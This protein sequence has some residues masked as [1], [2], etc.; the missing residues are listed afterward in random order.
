VAA[1][2]RRL[3]SRLG[4]GEYAELVAYELIRVAARERDFDRGRPGW[5][6]YMERIEREAETGRELALA[7]L[8]YTRQEMARYGRPIPRLY[9]VGADPDDPGDTIDGDIY[10]ALPP[11]APYRLNGKLTVK[12]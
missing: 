1:L 4:D 2:A 8:L 3:R 9:H 6:P 7:D 10:A 11:G 12:Y 5:Q